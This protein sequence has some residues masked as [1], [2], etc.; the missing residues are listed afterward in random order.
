MTDVE[1]LIAELKDTGFNHEN[2]KNIISQDS[3]PI[4]EDEPEE[5]QAT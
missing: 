5:G 2:L 4:P 3:E 1:K